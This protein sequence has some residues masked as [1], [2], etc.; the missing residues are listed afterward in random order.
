MRL[1][2]A[3][4]QGVIKLMELMNSSLKTNKIIT[5][6]KLIYRLNSNNLLN[7]LKLSIDDS[8]LNNNAW[9]TGFTEANEY[10]GVF[11]KEF[12]SKSEIRKKS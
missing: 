12:K 4:K 2:V 3:D 1:I 9:L 6:H 8:T 11:V 10:F 7:I 5:F